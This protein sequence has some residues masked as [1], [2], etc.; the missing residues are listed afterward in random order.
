[1]AISQK[2]QGYHG[3]LA[4]VLRP[5]PAP[6]SRCRASY[7][8]GTEQNPAAA[9]IFLEHP[10]RPGLVYSGANGGRYGWWALGDG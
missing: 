3:R 4:I 8:P 10:G 6:P 5:R 2:Q 1:M 7:P 9:S